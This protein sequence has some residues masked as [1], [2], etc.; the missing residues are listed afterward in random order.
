MSRDGVFGADVISI[1]IGGVPRSLN[2]SASVTS[3]PRLNLCQMSVG[4]CGL[5]YSIAD[6][7]FTAE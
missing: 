2:S 3:P 4:L 6:K 5:I 7:P 1:P